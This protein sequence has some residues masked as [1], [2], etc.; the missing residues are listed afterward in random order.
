MMFIVTGGAGF[1]GSNIVKGLNDRG[2]TDILVVDDL[3][4]SEKFRNLVGLHFTD[5]MDKDMLLDYLAADED[6]EIDVVIHQGA[7]S[8]TTER[9]GKY[10]MENNYAFTCCLA[11]WCIASN[12][13]FVYASSASVYGNGKKGFKEDF[14]NEAPINIYAYSKYL[15][16]Q[17]GRNWFDDVDTT[18]VGL[19]YFNVYGPGE[20][21]KGRM[22]SMAFHGFNQLTATGKIKLFRGIDGV[23]DGEQLRDFVFVKDVVDVVL[24]FALEDTG[25]RKKTTQ[26]VFNVGTGRARSFRELAEAVIAANGQGGSIE[27]VPFPEDLRGRYQNYT[28]AD[29]TALRKAGYKAKFTS[30]EDGVAEYVRAM[31]EV[32]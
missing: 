31:K 26:G 5:Y 7:C 3:T 9:D 4:N 15:F 21:H 20:A 29:L 27:F 30:L 6:L 24:H 11:E 19:R 32:Q 18:F 2:I 17:W 25:K 22:A 23:A 12:T 14:A 28:Q 8:D 1:I 13:P 10:M 16:D